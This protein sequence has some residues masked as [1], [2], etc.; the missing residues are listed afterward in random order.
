MKK[1]IVALLCSIFSLACAG[2]ALA[3][4]QAQ[5][6]PSL[7][8]QFGVFSEPLV[9]FGMPKAQ[10]TK[11]LQRAIAEYKM[12]GD[13]AQTAALDDF[14][15]LYPHSVWRVALLTNEGLA[16]A[17]TGEFTKA[18]KRL[19]TAWEEGRAA[20]AGRRKALADGAFAELLRLHAAFGHMDEVAKLLKSVEGRSLSG[21][22]RVA[23]TVAQEELWDMRHEP[24]TTFICGL[25]ALK[26]LFAT[27]A[28]GQVPDWLDAVKAPSGGMTLTRLAALSDKA[29]MPVQMVHR[30]VDQPIPVPSIVH[31]KV[32]H[33]ATIVGQRNDR[34][35]VK[36]AA[37]G[38]DLWMTRAAID[39]EASGYF[40]VPDEIATGPWRLVSSTEGRSVVGAGIT[41]GNNPDA[42]SNDDADVC[43]CGGGGSSS[44]MARY[45]VKAM[46]VSLSLHDTPV[47]YTPPKGP[48]V[49]VTLVYSQREANQPANFTYFN[50]GHKWTSNW[51]SYVQDNPRRPGS[52]VMVYLP[53][54]GARHYAGFNWNSGAFT[55][56]ER[57]GAQLI[58]VSRDPVVYERRMPDGSKYIYS[59]SDGNVY[60][61]RRVFLTKVVDAS[62]NN[63]S[64][65]YDGKMRLTAL[66]DS[67]GQQTTFQ[68]G[69]VH[70]PLRITGITDPFG[71]HAS[72]TYDNRGRLVDITDVIGMESQFTYDNGTF[73]RAMTTPYGTTHFASG[74]SG[75]TR[76]L[77]ITDPDGHTERVEY[78]H[79]APGIPFS[80]SPVPNGIR[81]F[82]AYI[83][84]RNTFFWDKA[85][86]ERAPGDYTKA[87]IYH[88]LHEEGLVY[89]GLT[90]GVLES[91]KQ[92]L[93]RRVWFNYPDQ[94]WAGGTGGFDKPSAIGR[95]LGDG[96]TQ[97][98]RL[99]YNGRGRVT[100]VIDPLGR[101][102]NYFYASNGIDLVKVTRKTGDGTDVLAIFTYNGHH[103]PLTYTDAAGEMTHYAYNSAGQLTRKTDP[104]GEVTG[105]IYNSD[106]YLLRIIDPNDE[107]YRSFTYDRFGRIASV[108]DSEGHTQVYQYDAL[109]R[110]TRVIYPDG[111]DQE[112]VWNK[113]DPAAYTDREGRT[114]RLTYNAERKLTSKIDP[115]G[116]IAK[117]RY[118]ANGKLKSLIDPNG[119]VTTWLRDIEGRPVA[120]VYPDGSKHTYAYD[121]AGRLRSKSD[122]VGQVTNYSYTLA[123]RLTGISYLHAV[124]P[125]PDVSFDYGHYYPRI[126]KM[127]DGHGTTHYSYYPAGVPGAGR[128]RLAQGNNP[129]DR[130]EYSYDLLGRPATRTVDGAVE[131]FEYDSLGRLV[132]DKNV[133]GHFAID[134]FGETN[135]PIARTIAG[136]PFRTRYQYEGNLGDRRL[137]AILNETLV[138][139]HWRPV[140][141]FSFT[142]G[143]DGL[144]RS[145]SATFGKHGSN[146]GRHL[147]WTK[148]RHRG[149][150]HAPHRGVLKW[151]NNLDSAIG[152]TSTYTYDAALRLTSVEGSSS[153]TYG[154]D[155]AGNITGIA[156]AD[157]STPISFNDLNQIQT[158]GDIAYRYDA[159]G[160]L[161]D[162][163][164][165]TYRW[166]AANRLIAIHNK[167]TGHISRFAYDGLSRRTR[168]TEIEPGTTPITADFLWCG[169]R[170][171]EKRKGDGEVV[172]RYFAQGEMHQGQAL[173]YAQDQVGSVVAVVDHS[174]SVVGRISYDAY[175]NI[176]ASSGT[177][178][179]YRYAGLFYH[180]ASG[181]S[182]GT[183][184]AYDPR[185]G[186]WLSRDPLREVG[187]INLY[188]YVGSNPIN[189][190]DPHGTWFG[191]DDLVA[192]V[193]GAAIGVG[194]QVISD[195]ISGHWSGWEVYVG[196][197]VGGA[198]GGELALYGTAAG[199]AGLM[200]A[201]AAAGAAGDFATQVLQMWT[202]KECSFNWSEFGFSLSTGALLG[203]FGP[204]FRI[205]GISAGRNSQR[206]ILKQM[207]SKRLG[208]NAKTI[209]LRTALKMGGGLLIPGLRSDLIGAGVSGV[210]G[211]SGGGH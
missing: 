97:L 45:S 137:K 128:L 116:Q 71:R 197:A 23:R 143:P 24:G 201:G 52:R 100:Q 92:P 177:L 103:Q 173:Y 195:A 159:N 146:H 138:H 211:L 202:G 90:S 65:T 113:L 51:L 7:A 94:P 106:G 192:T 147:G 196:S 68:Y 14:L 48:A 187:G 1:L 122:P 6:A 135:Q 199:P 4:S 153:R 86:M 81:A 144:I 208:G 16:Y 44:G 115:L 145:R 139:R 170:I 172:A 127:T 188:G 179:D 30:N 38:H 193:G 121:M 76:W 131:K 125:T 210:M 32:G 49:P 5:G 101:Q 73:I 35:H 109:N 102:T 104:L 114:T 37:M 148:G 67:L 169:Q 80:A 158:V 15:S 124:N 161:I 84:S 123:D 42:T 178:P 91:V 82:N 185:D 60:Y 136:V 43:G 186:R 58:E 117:F 175:G 46:L 209:S 166:D 176:N 163:G 207:I 157:H 164:I 154:Y 181:L 29:Q 72:V 126:T 180:Q 150:D 41:R 11:A 89:R 9:P 31:W 75:T 70:Y 165:R 36:D 77:E 141:N 61:P 200:A 194:M 64:L 20:P 184:R 33:F 107:T 167:L 171:C 83:N 57:T 63:V 50:L 18:L 22:A 191:L 26:N 152:G 88:W 120:R 56:E 160:N 47:G 54:G 206:A 85:A 98:T 59:A 27:Q 108:T 129:H 112:I 162:D 21:P 13:P 93:E 17:H 53:G 132:G 130:I 78:R 19:R 204:E 168:E 133:L 87:R 12:A 203:R 140:A 40:L 39:S 156:N 183:Y 99:K 3:S 149:W 142:T 96:K 62:G 110:L 105:Y 69:D 205:S 119:N 134:Y 55:P 151:L 95:V 190:L 34:F 25:I 182:L 66:T 28:S 2:S 8:R 79:S 111:T 74:Q 174:G 10:V 155:A 118:Y 189:R 198:V